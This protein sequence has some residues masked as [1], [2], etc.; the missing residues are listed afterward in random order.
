MKIYLLDGESRQIPSLNIAGAIRDRAGEVIGAE[1][2]SFA[3]ASPF[4]K[5]ISIR[6]ISEDLTE[7]DGAVNTLKTELKSMTALKDVVDDNQEG[8]EEINITLKDKAWLLG[9]N[10]QQV[11]G[12]VRQ[13]FFGSEVQRL[14]RGI[15]EVK[16]WVRYREEDRQRIDQ[17]KDRTV[18]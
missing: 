8:L 16:V 12:Q 7:L 10:L 18:I 13:G 17:L 5:P 6:L 3:A 1:S 2:V 15:D 4:G 11:I 14:Q 9:L